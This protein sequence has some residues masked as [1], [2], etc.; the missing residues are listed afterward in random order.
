MQLGP[1]LA[2]GEPRRRRDL[3][4]RHVLAVGFRPDAGAVHECARTNLGPAGKNIYKHMDDAAV[5]FAV[6]FAMAEARRRK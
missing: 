1:R 3:A 6:E 4:V 5:V 2:L